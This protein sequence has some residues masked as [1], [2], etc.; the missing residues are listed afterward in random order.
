MRNIKFAE[1]TFKQFLHG[2]LLE[3]IRFSRINFE[4]SILPYEFTHLRYF[5]VQVFALIAGSQYTVYIHLG[6]SS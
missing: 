6:M 4:N 5:M 3:M 1:S 2:L